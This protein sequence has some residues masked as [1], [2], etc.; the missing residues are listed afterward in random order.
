MSVIIDENVSASLDEKLG[1]NVWWKPDIDKKTL[2]S[3]C[4]KRSSPGALY[5]S[6]YFIALIT[7]GYLAFITWGSYWSI[8]FFWL[9]GII[10]AFS[11]AYDHEARHRT[12][13]KQRDT[14]EELIIKNKR[15]HQIAIRKLKNEI[16]ELRK[17]GF[18]NE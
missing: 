5:V 6:L 3:L 13:F 18:N 10:Y 7:M 9:Y 16:K 11:G 17:E 1:A 8:L 4:V 12:L 15:S 14:L 2:K